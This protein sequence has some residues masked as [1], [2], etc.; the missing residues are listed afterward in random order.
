MMSVSTG[1]GSE[2]RCWKALCNIYLQPPTPAL[3]H[4]PCGR[5][6]TAMFLITKH[7]AQGREYLNPKLYPKENPK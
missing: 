1:S 5:D 6:A 4:Q 2:C 7:V 3:L